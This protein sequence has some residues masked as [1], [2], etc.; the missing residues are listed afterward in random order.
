[1][2]ATKPQS[3][4]DEQLD[5]IEADV[6]EQMEEIYKKA[7]FVFGDVVGDITCLV[8]VQARKAI[9]LYEARIASLEEEVTR[10][11]QDIERLQQWCEELQDGQDEH[12]LGARLAIV[13]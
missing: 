11:A 2:P 7:G 8:W 5:R 12:A 3:T 13:G 4:G 10:Q 1:M 9:E 6:D